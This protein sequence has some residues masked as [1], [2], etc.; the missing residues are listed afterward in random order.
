MRNDFNEVSDLG[1]ASALSVSDFAIVRVD[2]SNPRRVV[3]VFE[4]STGLQEAIE[5]YFSGKLLVPAEPFFSQIRSLKNR[6]YV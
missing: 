2:K 3:F 5:D 6:I 1:L 4:K